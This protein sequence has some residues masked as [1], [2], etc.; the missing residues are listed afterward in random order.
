[1]TKPLPTLEWL[2]VCDYA[3]RDEH[4]KLCLIGLFEALHSL[5]LPGF[6]PV[7]CVAIGLTDGQ[8]EY[9]IGLQIQAPSG[10]TM[11]LAL[12]PVV[13]KDRHAKAR[14]VIRLA[15]MQFGEFGRYTF[16]LKV[17]D[18]PMDYPV[19]LV[20]HLEAKPGITPAAP[21]TPVN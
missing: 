6:L 11:D 1:M 20:D 14:A 2:H 18:Q 17:D 8:G 3:F 16:R 12:P 21:E 4:G 10:K 7:Y 15:S 9:K 13:L 19:H 5:K